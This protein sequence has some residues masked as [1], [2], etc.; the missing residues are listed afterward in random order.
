MVYLMLTSFVLGMGIPTTP[1]YIVVA[2]LGAPA[3]IKAG[4]PQLVAHMFVFYYAIPV[5][6]HPARV[7]R[8]LRGGCHRRKQGHGDGL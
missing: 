8:G 5:L 4:A 3:L 2:T 7:R 1:A 6:H